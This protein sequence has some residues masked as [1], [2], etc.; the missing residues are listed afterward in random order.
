MRATEAR[1]V[2]VVGD[3]H[4]PFCKDGYLEF[5][6][7]Q[8]DTWNCTDVV[9]IGDII[10]NHYTSYHEIDIEAEYTGKQELEYAIK[11]IARWKQVFEKATVILGN[12]DRMI[13][14]RSQTSLI[15]SKWIKSYKEVLEVPNWEFVDRLVIDGVQ[16]IHGE[17]GTART[18]CRADMMNT[19]QGHL[20][21]QTYIEHYVGQNFRV[22]GMQVGCGI[23]HDSYAMAYAKRGKK[24]SIACAVV[25]GGTT[26]IN[27]LMPL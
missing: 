26:P 19:V 8:Y 15:P 24:P 21:T 6:Q 17:A 3:L 11:K 7:E 16:Y 2:L 9:F 23:D 5:C 20:H 25:L 14:R 1:N 12:H 13:M 10:D 18:K 4:E 22:F 27:L